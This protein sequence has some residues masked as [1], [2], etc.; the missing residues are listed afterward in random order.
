MYCKNCGKELNDN[1]D[2]CLGCGVAVGNGNSF[3]HSCGAS[4]DEDA[5]FCTNCGAAQ[6]KQEQ[7]QNDTITIPSSNTAGIAKRSILTA[8]I[9]SL[10]TCGIYGIYWFVCLTNE[11]NKASGREND[12][13][14]GMAF[15]LTLVTCGI[16]SYIWAYKMGE[17]RDSLTNEN[18]S[19]SILYLL[20]YLF[21]LGRVVYA[22]AQD[23]INKAIDRG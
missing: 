20:L 2:V 16:Y 3:C 17:K 7:I 19:S 14:G 22:L 9:L 12:T 1:Q 15:L 5:R 8:I 18:A 6:S 11:M 4:V 10:I 23:A 13:N 21:G